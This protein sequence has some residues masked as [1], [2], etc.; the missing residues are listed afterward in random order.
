VEAF[1]IAEEE[2][3]PTLAQLAREAAVEADWNTNH[4]SAVLFGRLSRDKALLQSV[5]QDAVY[6]AVH[7]HVEEAMRHRRVT[8]IRQVQ[9][10]RQAGVDRKGAALALANSIA[11]S[12]FDFP[13]AGGVKL[14]DATGEQVAEAA[15]RY[16]A[17]ASD[18][19]IKG[20]WLHTVAKRVPPDKRVRDVCTAADLDTLLQ[21]AQ[22][23]V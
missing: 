14:G 12:L 16:S 2:E 6:D 20:A 10:E 19:S 22:K 15:R 11:A 3:K 8:L 21:K 13:L 9:A 23:N 4:A 5:V 7:Q 1:K 18:M 17:Q